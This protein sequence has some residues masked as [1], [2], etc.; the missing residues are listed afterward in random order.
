[1]EAGAEREL[2]ELELDHDEEDTDDGVEEEPGRGHIRQLLSFGLGPVLE[3]SQTE[4]V[5]EILVKATLRCSCKCPLTCKCPPSD[6]TDGQEE[7]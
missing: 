5:C 2:L 7:Y 1:M 4:R 3:G 6:T